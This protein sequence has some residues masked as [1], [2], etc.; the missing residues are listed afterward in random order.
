M[1]IGDNIQQRDSG[2][3]KV[4]VDG[5]RRPKEGNKINVEIVRKGG[6]IDYLQFKS[7]IK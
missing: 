1:A 7:I 6:N 4:K 5:S 3:I 2:S